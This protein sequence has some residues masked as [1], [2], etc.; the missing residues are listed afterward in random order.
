[1]P[2][3]SVLPVFSVLWNGP[4]A[5]L[6]ESIHSFC[7]RMPAGG[8]FSY[9]FNVNALLALLLVSLICGSVGSLVVG[10]RMAF[11]S[12]AL[13]HCAFAGVSIGF[14]L[15]E[16]LWTGPGQEKMFWIYV[17][18]IMAVF[19]VLVGL[20]IAAVRQRTTLASDTVI[21]VF[22]AAAIGLAAILRKL[23][24]SRALFSLEDFLFGDPIQVEAADILVLVVLALFTFGVL[25][26]LYNPLL[27]TGFNSSLA[28]SRREPVRLS[29]YVFVVLLALIVNLCLRTVGALLINALLIVPAATVVNVTRNLRQLFRWTLLL[30]IIVTVGGLFA[31]WDIEIFTQ[32]YTRRPIQLG[33]PGTIILL[34]VGC[35]AVSLLVGPWMR[36]RRQAAT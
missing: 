33:I 30:C 4:A 25:V 8:F 31:S 20:G 3:A 11:F 12:D 29:Q 27:L 1:M 16:A 21:G 35:F 7:A 5:W 22:F 32:R 17:T 9:D 2:I 13:A 10:S 26:W 14:V 23:M 28:L 18:P 19:G 6:E 34:S 24:Q 15:F 36:G